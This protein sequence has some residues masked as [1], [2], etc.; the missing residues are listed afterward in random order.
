MGIDHCRR[1]TQ[2]QLD[3]G[4]VVMSPLARLSNGLLHAFGISSTQDQDVEIERETGINPSDLMR[5]LK[6]H[7]VNS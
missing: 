6:E 3:E 5:D 1:Y 2:P 7:P 4:R